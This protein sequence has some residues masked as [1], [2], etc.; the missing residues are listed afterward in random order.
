VVAGAPESIPSPWHYKL[1][2]PTTVSPLLAHSHPRLLSRIATTAVACSKWNPS[3]LTGR[4]TDVR[5]SVLD[6]G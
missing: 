4:F 1:V 3:S 5:A 2:A 6:L